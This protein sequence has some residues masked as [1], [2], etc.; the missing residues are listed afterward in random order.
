MDL[1]WESDLLF[2]GY[3]YYETE[4]VTVPWREEGQKIKKEERAHI[5]RD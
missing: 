3:Y 1:H 5:G 4:E 2:A